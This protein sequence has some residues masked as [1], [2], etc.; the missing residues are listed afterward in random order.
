LGGYDPLAKLC[1]PHKKGN[2]PFVALDYGALY[3]ALVLLG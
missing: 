3:K 1:A 2:E